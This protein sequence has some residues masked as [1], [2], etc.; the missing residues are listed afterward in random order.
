MRRESVSFS[1]KGRYFRR[2]HRLGLLRIFDLSNSSIIFIGN[3]T[4]AFSKAI[5]SISALG[6]GVG[7]C[8]IFFG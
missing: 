4:Q 7:F 1:N 3:P 8:F 5:D 6:K 2:F